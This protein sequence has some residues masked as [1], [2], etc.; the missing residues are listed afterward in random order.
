[1]GTVRPATQRTVD[2]QMDAAADMFLELEAQF[3]KWGVQDHDDDTWT[4]ILMEEMGE[5]AGAIIDLKSERGEF[6]HDVLYRIRELGRDAKR[7][8]EG[9]KPDR[10]KP[11]ERHD[12]NHELTQVAAVAIAF[13]ENRNRTK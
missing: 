3:Q 4:L 10:I 12:V 13:I 1:M 6:A 2:G 9:D 8:L 7:A 11:G 5:A